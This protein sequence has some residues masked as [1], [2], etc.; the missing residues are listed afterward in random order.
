MA[1]LSINDGRELWGYVRT[2]C[3][4]SE[5]DVQHLLSDDDVDL[6]A[7]CWASDVELLLRVIRFG[8]HAY[9]AALSFVVLPCRSAAADPGNCIVY[10]VAQAYPVCDHAEPGQAST[11]EAMSP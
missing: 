9:A 6:D 1:L 10:D 3:C 11:Y 5:S 8:C 2:A 4:M 7:V